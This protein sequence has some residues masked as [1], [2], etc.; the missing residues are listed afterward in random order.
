MSEVASNLQF[1]QKERPISTGKT[2]TQYWVCQKV[3]DDRRGNHI[4]TYR[5]KI[6]FVV[7]AYCSEEKIA[8]GVCFPGRFVLEVKVFDYHQH[9]R[10]AHKNNIK[11]VGVVLNIVHRAP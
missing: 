8:K 10:L 9:Q 6:R 1:R 2:V 11:I 7:S 3:D 5:N 4:Y